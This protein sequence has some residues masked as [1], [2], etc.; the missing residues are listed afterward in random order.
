MLLKRVS[1]TWCGREGAA[2]S[3]EAWIA[4]LNRQVK[5]AP[6]EGESAWALREGPYR[7]DIHYDTLA[8]VR[9]IQRWLEGLR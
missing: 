4:F 5:S 1:L 8:L 3:G 6:F 7:P 2:L 9:A